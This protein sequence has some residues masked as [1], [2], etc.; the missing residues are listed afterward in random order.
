M[1]D[2]GLGIN[3]SEAQDYGGYVWANDPTA[4]S[5]T[6]AGPYQFNNTGR[7]NTAGRL[8]GNTGQYRVRFPSLKPG[9]RSTAVITA[10]GAGKEYCTIKGW[11]SDGSTGTYVYVQCYDYQGKARD[12]RFTLT[13]LTDEAILF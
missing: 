1:T 12:A 9:N 7:T 3:V 5:Y 11:T 4:T 8:D 10:Y 2:V 6:P 13:Y